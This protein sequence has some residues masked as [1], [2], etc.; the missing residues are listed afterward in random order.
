M[1]VDAVDVLFGCCIANVQFIVE[2]DCDDDAMPIVDFVRFD[3]FAVSSFAL[4]FRCNTVVV[5]TNFVTFLTAVLSSSSSLIDEFCCKCLSV[6]FTTGMLFTI[7]VFILEAFG[8]IISRGGLLTLRFVSLSWPSFEPCVSGDPII[9][10]EFP[11]CKFVIRLI[12]ARS[13]W[14]GFSTAGTS[15]SFDVISVSWIIMVNFFFISF[16]SFL[17]SSSSTSAFTHTNERTWFVS[18]S[19]SKYPFCS[20]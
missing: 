6:E 16:T 5:R 2:F 3:V 20:K 18:R 12:I 7:D 14:T 1:S 17:P 11:W 4:A 15:G 19:M 10:F 13:N 8:G 9:S